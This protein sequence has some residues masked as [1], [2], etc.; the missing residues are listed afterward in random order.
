MKKAVIYFSGAGATKHVA[1]R[2]SQEIQATLLPVEKGDF[3]INDFDALIIGTPVYHAAPAGV[4]MRYFTDLKPLE[5]KTPAF[6]YNTRGLWSFNTNRI[7]AKLLKEKN[8]IIVMDREYRSPASDGSLLA[9]FIK[10]FFEF[11][12]GL[13]E[14]IASDC[15]DFMKILNAETPEGYLLKIPR[16]RFG[17]IINAPNKLAGK[18]FPLKIHLH[19]GK[20]TDCGLCVKNCPYKKEKCDN[21]YRCVHHCPTKALSLSKRKT[22]VKTLKYK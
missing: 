15:K 16:F 19:K 8:I 22:P 9:P 10:S 6:I 3:D 4:I 18:V 21:C 1:E 12:S 2:I 14:K 5:K 20:C 13:E 17:S 7:L 11:E